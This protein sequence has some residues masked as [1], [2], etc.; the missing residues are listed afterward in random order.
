[1]T[2]TTPKQIEKELAAI[3]KGESR[4][5]WAQSELLDAIESSGYWH[6]DSNSDS[7]TSWLESNA[8]RFGVKPPMLWRRLTAGRFVRQIKS[9]L[10][11]AGIELPDLVKIGENVG[12]ES[13]ELLSKLERA[14]PE[15]V[16]PDMARKVFSGD[17]TRAELKSM[18][19]TYRPVLGGKTARGRGVLPPR[20]N[21]TDPDQFN[22]LMEAMSL[23]SLKAAGPGWSGHSKPKLY[24]VFLHVTPD[25][26]RVL[27]GS[28]LFSAVVVI[29]TMDGDIEYHGFRYCAMSIT[30]NSSKDQPAA[31]Y[32]DF[33]WFMVPPRFFNERV[34]ARML[35]DLPDYAG[36]VLLK[37][38]NVEVLKKAA[39]TPATGNL[40]D[41]LIS[42]L[43][44]RS[45]EG[46]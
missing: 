30:D 1:M 45:I 39:S 41:K 38:G 43:F 20:I 23:D 29:R 18:W 7:F 26:Y 36:L 10:E 5:W 42:A 33:L 17:T 3:E 24:Q 15:D 9:R 11:D 31:A 28:Y 44:S 34:K 6:R 14:L 4:S 46:K 21:T 27:R 35:N 13:V 8:T 16:F 12:P 22:S 19:A 32:C 25:G 2:L 37:D 40:R